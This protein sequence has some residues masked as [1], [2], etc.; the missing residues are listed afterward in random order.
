MLHLISTS[1]TLLNLAMNI[2]NLNAQRMPE[3]NEFSF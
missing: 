2:A 3:K 1:E